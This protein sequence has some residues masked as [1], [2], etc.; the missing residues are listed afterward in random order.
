M[1][2]YWQKP[3]IFADSREFFR[4]SPVPIY[5]VSNIDRQDILA[6]LVYHQLAPEGVFTSED[7]RAY[8]PRKELFQL[9]L[10]RVGLK[11]GEVIHIGDSLGSDVKGA[12]QVGIRTLWLNRSGKAVPEGVASISSL[13]DGIKHIVRKEDL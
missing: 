9:A 13:L 1:F 5:L 10:G 6:A 4:R 3:P 2:A 12:S 11:P 8:K 7:A